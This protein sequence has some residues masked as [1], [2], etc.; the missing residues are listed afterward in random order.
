MRNLRNSSAAF[1]VRDLEAW[2]LGAILRPAPTSVEFCVIGS[3]R[4]SPMGRRPD[5]AQGC[6]ALFFDFALLPFSFVILA[7]AA[8]LSSSSL[9]CKRAV[10]ASVTLNAQ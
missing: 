3:P 7:A 6:L 5:A 2:A 4:D 1:A 10:R 9:V 8:G